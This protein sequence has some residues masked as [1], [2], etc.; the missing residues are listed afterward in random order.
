VAHGTQAGLPL[1]Y[2]GER[3]F[4]ENLITPSLIP[5]LKKGRRKMRFILF[6]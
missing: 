5:P 6:S 1:E 3:E 2:M 4:I